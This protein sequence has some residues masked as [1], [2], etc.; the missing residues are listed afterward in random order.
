MGRVVTLILYSVILLISIAQPATADLK[1]IRER[2]ILRHLGIPYA[3]FVTGT[4]EGMDV[5]IIKAFADYLGVRYEFVKTDWHDVFGD[6][7]G[8]KVKPKGKDEV[9]LIGKVSVRGDVAAS[10]ITVLPW[11]ERIVV[12]SRPLF[13]NQVWV[14][15]RMDYP[16][17]PIL[18]LGKVEKDI[19]TTKKIISGKTIMGKFGTCLDPR[20]YGLE[21][22][23]GKL[24]DFPGSINDIAPAVI[25]G[26]AEMAVL[27]LPDAL[28]AL[29]RWPG[30]LKIIGPVSDKQYMA[31]AFSKDSPQLKE[32]F[33]RFLAKLMKDGRYHRIVKKY[34]PHAF[35]FDPAFFRKARKGSL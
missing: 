33:D 34:Y 3:K 22:I 2:G 27:D 20:L 13:P 30:M 14:V 7:T 6:L 15:T 19:E 24:V 5:E 29:Q 4:G 28:V 35:R 9:E 26:K 8:W 25:E 1:D 12:F 23:A 16:V 18:S 17:K 10:G 31:A 21:G 11:R 32:E